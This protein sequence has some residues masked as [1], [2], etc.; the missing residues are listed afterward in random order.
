MA[1]IR[2]RDGKFQL[3]ILLPELAQYRYFNIQFLNLRGEVSKKVI[4]ENAAMPRIVTKYTRM[5]R[6][7][8]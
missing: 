5:Q 1:T 3:D 4:L 7:L 6:N 2:K 8:L